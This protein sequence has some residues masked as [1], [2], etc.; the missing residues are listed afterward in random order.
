MPILKYNSFS[1]TAIAVNGVEFPFPY[2]SRSKNISDSN[3]QHVNSNSYRIEGNFYL[4]NPESF[5][6]GGA[7]QFTTDTDGDGIKDGVEVLLS[8]KTAIENFFSQSHKKLETD[9]GD[10]NNAV[11]RSINFDSSTWAGLIDY[12][13]ELEAVS[14]EEGSNVIDIVNEYSIQ[15]SPN[16]SN[17]IVHKVSARGLNTLTTNNSNAFENARSWVTAKLWNNSLSEGG[18][19]SAIHVSPSFGS[20]SSY[21]GAPPTIGGKHPPLLLT[22]V[23]ETSDRMSGSYSVSESYEYVDAMWA[24]LLDLDPPASAA[25]HQDGRK[26]IVKYAFDTSYDQDRM[27]TVLDVDLQIKYSTINTFGFDEVVTYLLGDTTSSYQAV[28]SD[29]SCDP[30]N[31]SG[32]TR[33]YDTIA[34]RI[35]KKIQSSDILPRLA[36]SPARLSSLMLY[37]NSLQSATVDPDIGVVSI[38]LQYDTD[39][40]MWGVANTDN[41]LFDHDY[42]LSTDWVTGN[43]GIT[44]NCKILCDPTHKLSDKLDIVH[45]FFNLYKGTALHA[46]LLERI[47][48]DYNTV[49]RKSVGTADGPIRN[50]YESGGF[51]SANRINPIPESLSANINMSTG[52]GSISA[53]FSDEDYVSGVQSLNYRVNVKP[54]IIPYEPKASV[55]GSLARDGHY[56]VFNPGGLRRTTWGASVSAKGAKDYNGVS[57]NTVSVIENAIVNVMNSDGTAVIKEEDSFDIG[58]N[59]ANSSFQFSLMDSINFWNYYPLNGGFSQQIWPQPTSSLNMYSITS[60]VAQAQSYI[61]NKNQ[62]LQSVSSLATTVTNTNIA[63]YSASLAPLSVAY[64]A[65][66][67]ALFNYNLAVV[68]LPNPLAG[69]FTSAGW[70]TYYNLQQNVSN[71][72]TM[73]TFAASNVKAMSASVGIYNNRYR[74]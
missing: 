4:S 3:G 2:I 10:L 36:S 65:Y 33:Y 71:T 7:G 50:A 19:I 23:A 54:P 63:N 68:S 34:K 69:P 61:D 15:E 52:E 62:S 74:I 72:A 38:K 43:T 45:G 42:S 60:I 39:I 73:L 13:I 70:A 29:D 31:P 57:R 18:T 22:D 55:V 41:W 8:A 21:G 11:V 28:G 66:Y 24:D 26:M 49:L 32:L 56:I 6:T 59:T 14:T 67:Q 51:I 9:F 35:L 53:S 17:T 46:F 40:K 20:S 47:S 37:A 5:E 16:G 64:N 30:L 48:S 58:T 25:A 1:F 44:M 27:C 12:S